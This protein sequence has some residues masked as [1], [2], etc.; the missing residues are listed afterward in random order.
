MLIYDAQGNATYQ[1]RPIE[2]EF[3]HAMPFAPEEFYC[4]PQIEVVNCSFTILGENTVE[5]RVELKIC[6]AIYEKKKMPLIIYIALGDEEDKRE[7][8][9]GLVVYYACEG[10][11]VWDIAR[12]YN[13]AVE[14]IMQINSLESDVLDSAKPL[15]I[16]L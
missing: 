3:R 9:N 14:E 4:D 1:E 6:A 13:S 12:R 7:T 2:Y 8:A 10:E 15:I 11:E 5:V 16:C